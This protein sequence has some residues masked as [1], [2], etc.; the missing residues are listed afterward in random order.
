MRSLCLCLVASASL[1]LGGCND[2][3]DDFDDGTHKPQDLPALPDAGTTPYP[4]GPYDLVVGA[5][6]DN[7]A[8]Q[9]FVDAKASSSE[10]QT[11]RLSDFYNPPDGD[12]TYPA[13]S[14]YGE[15]TK[16]PTALVIDIASVWCGPCNQEAKTVFP[17]LY[18]KYHPCGGELLFALVDSAK[19]KT[20]ATVDDLRAWT[21]AYKVDYPSVLDSSRQLAKLYPS[22]DFPDAAII[23][24]RTM[25][26]VEVV[27]SVPDDAFWQRYEEHLDPSCLPKD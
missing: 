27:L 23:D 11:I 16:R 24:T 4:L 14:P 22:H 6:I 9:G 18:A 2:P 19:P 8:F 13:G 17:A 21:K 25:K 5:T 10:L 15:G 3:S 20:P 1:V 26:I 7:F 12:P